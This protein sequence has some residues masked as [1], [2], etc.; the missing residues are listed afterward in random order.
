MEKETYSPFEWKNNGEKE[1]KKWCCPIEMSVT[2]VL[3]VQ[4]AHKPMK[5]L[6]GT[7]SVYTCGRIII[8]IDIVLCC[9]HLR[10]PS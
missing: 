3:T 10:L 2:A 1:E 8:V 7:T 9:F 4:C 5:I 6:R